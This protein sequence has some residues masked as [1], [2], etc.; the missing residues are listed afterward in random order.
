[1][2]AGAGCEVIGPGT[3]V[4]GAVE[5]AVGGGSTKQF[6]EVRERHLAKGGSGF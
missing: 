3:G 5:K 4:L 2:G 6:P 1:M